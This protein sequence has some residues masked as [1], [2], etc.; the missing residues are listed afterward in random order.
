MLDSG[1]RPIVADISVA[2]NHSE[3]IRVTES[4]HKIGDAPQR[5]APPKPGKVSAHAN[6]NDR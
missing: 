1:V 5:P 4:I 3:V 6:E 2:S